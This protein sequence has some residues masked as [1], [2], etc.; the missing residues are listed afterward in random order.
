M[1][2]FQNNYRCIN[3]GEPFVRQDSAGTVIREENRK[4]DPHYFLFAEFQS[5]GINFIPSFFSFHTL[6]RRSYA[7][8]NVTLVHS[9]PHSFSFQ[10][11]ISLCFGRE[12]GDYLPVMQPRQ[13]AATGRFPAR[14]LGG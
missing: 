8:A 7:L 3:G 10:I 4:T 1:E 2:S 9:N 12:S 14:T 11:T 6:F 13:E 5:V